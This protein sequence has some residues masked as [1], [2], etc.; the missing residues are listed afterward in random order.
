MRKKLALLYV[1]LS[2]SFIYYNYTFAG[3]EGKKPKGEQKTAQQSASGGGWM[4]LGDVPRQRDDGE[5]TVKEGDTLWDI[6]NSFLN[7][8]FKWPTLWEK[9]PYIANP[10]LIYPGNKI[11]LFFPEQVKTGE[12]AKEAGV[13]AAPTVPEGLPVEKLQKPEE[14][15]LVTPLA[16]EKPKEEQ[17]PLAMVEKEPTPQPVPEI[18]KIAS[19]IMERNG[20]ISAKGME[21]SGIIVGSKEERL[22]LSQGDTVYI[23][24]ANGVNL[25]DGDKFTVFAT[26][27]EVKHPVTEEPIGFLTDTL[28]ILEVIR[29]EKDGVITARIVKSYKEITKGAR[30][31]FYEQPVNEVV[32]KKSEKA[33][34]GFIIAS[35]E[36][37]VGVAEN[38]IVYLDKGENSGLEQGN[39][40][41]IFRPTTTV[42]DPMSSKK[43]TITLPPAELGRLIIIRVEDDTSTAFIIKSKQ[44]IYKGDRVKTAE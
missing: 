33:V 32:V 2:V 42:D 36:K 8:P 13:E 23:S 41:D 31:K 24:V 15:P 20:F 40:M 9:N 37:K 21:G 19:A 17:A 44:V 3:D 27:G 28:G 43:K 14:V 6:T 26:V 29:I 34:D 39:T 7:N 5:Y 1:C 11:R 16:E 22:L 30:L 38:D 25:I 35:L 4:R 18:V 10:H 12:K